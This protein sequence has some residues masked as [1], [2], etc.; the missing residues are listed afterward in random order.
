MTNIKINQI[1]LLSRLIILNPM[2][3]LLRNL[4]IIPKIAFS[5][6]STKKTQKKTLL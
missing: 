4:L 3:N 1:S 6:K 5:K 2:T